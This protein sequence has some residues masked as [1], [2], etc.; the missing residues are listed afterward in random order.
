[1]QSSLNLSK[2]FSILMRKR[3]LNVLKAFARRWLLITGVQC[4]LDRTAVCKL[5]YTMKNMTFSQ[6]C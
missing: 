4:V 1:M 2:V 6:L 3:K 5:A